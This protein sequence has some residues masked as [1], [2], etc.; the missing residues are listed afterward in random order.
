MYF[1]FLTL[2][3]PDFLCHTPAQHFL[4]EGIG[5]YGCTLMVRGWDL[6]QGRSDR[7]SLAVFCFSRAVLKA[8]FWCIGFLLLLP[9]LLLSGVADTFLCRHYGIGSVFW[10]TH[11]RSLGLLRFWDW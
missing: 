7:K 9:P 5:V 2:L 6:Y 3:T 1:S 10:E 8:F 11:L 4:R